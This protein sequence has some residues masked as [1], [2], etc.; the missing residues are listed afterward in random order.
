MMGEDKS[1][2]FDILNELFNISVGQAASLLSEMINRTLILNVPSIEI[3]DIKDN[4][5]D[6]DAFLP[7]DVDGI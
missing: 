7:M 3:I 2:K 1:L 6:V 5:A 4:S